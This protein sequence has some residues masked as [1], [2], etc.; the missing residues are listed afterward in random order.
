MTEISSKFDNNGESGAYVGADGIARGLDTYAGSETAMQ[1][2]RAEGAQRQTG[3][4]IVRGHRDGTTL[5][6]HEAQNAFLNLRGCG[7]KGEHRSYSEAERAADEFYAKLDRL[8]REV[9]TLARNT[10]Q[11]NLRF[12][13][14]AI[15]S[16][17]L[18]QYQGTM[19]TD[20][21]KLF[22]DPAY[23]L[24]RYKECRENPARDYLHEIFHCV[25]HHA[26]VGPEMDQGLWNLA[27]DIAAEN[28]ITDLHLSCT[29]AEREKKQQGDI[30]RI[31]EKVKLM[32]AEKIYHMLKEEPPTTEE[33]IRMMGLF[34][35][36]DHT[37]W[38][39]PKQDYDDIETKKEKQDMSDE[40]RHEED[41]S[42]EEKR[43]QKREEKAEETDES[44]E[45]EDDEQQAMDEASSPDDADESRS[46]LEKHWDDVAREMQTDLETFSREIGDQKGGLMQSLRAVNREHYDYTAFLRRFAA[47]GETL[48]VNDDEFDYIFYTY[49]MQLYGKMPLV[50]PLE[51]KEEMKIKEFVIAIDTSGSVSGPLVQKFV[52]KTYNILS[53]RESFFSK[54]N[55][56][57]IQCDAEI[58]EDKKITS[59]DEFDEYIRTMELK[60]FGGTDFRPVFDYVDKLK[61]NHEF[62]NLK[63]LIYFTDGYGVFPAHQPDYQ[64]AFVFVEDEYNNPEV[65]VWAIKLVLQSDEV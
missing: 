5:D 28:A 56:H 45:D 41:E 57:I 18:E 46:D 47:L 58:Q 11:V 15:G 42:S 40:A 59:P 39:A 10:L 14:S 65:P 6:C 37:D 38:Y 17:K 30:D 16:L 12:L 21:E 29:A 63:G 61:K 62:T 23:V 36:D 1:Q 25:F 20:G 64:T 53:E 3:E 33:F 8:G 51:Y 31:K 32:S 4:S 2:T 55:I 52:T 34:T 54:I 43:R 35:N 26:F 7:A 44:P 13:D 27:C 49:G 24:K 48:R 9:I 50:E 19:A 60:G 22:Y